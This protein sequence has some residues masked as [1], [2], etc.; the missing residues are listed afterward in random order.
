VEIVAREKG[1]KAVRLTEL[2]KEIKLLLMKRIMNNF[3]TGEDFC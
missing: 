1:L 2:V 3:K